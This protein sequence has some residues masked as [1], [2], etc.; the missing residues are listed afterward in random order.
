MVRGSSNAPLF[1][2]ILQSPLID[3]KNIGLIHGPNH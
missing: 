2:R 1:G 3:Q